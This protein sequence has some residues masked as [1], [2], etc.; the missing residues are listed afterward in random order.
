MQTDLITKVYFNEHLTHSCVGMPQG[1][2]ALSSSLYLESVDRACACT[3][4]LMTLA[5]IKIDLVLICL[6]IRQW[7]PKAMLKISA[8]KRNARAETIEWRHRSSMRLE[9]AELICHLEILGD[10]MLLLLNHDTQV[11]KR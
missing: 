11:C 10:K 4:N 9:S 7:F 1:L 5:N 8:G 2:Q 3:H 6:R